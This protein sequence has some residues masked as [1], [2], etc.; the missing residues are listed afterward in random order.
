MAVYP[1]GLPTTNAT[2]VFTVTVGGIDL[3]AQ[4]Q[5]I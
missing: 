5:D 4:T 3:A 2:N 1:A